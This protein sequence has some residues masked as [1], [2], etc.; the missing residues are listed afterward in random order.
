MVLA[1]STRAITVQGR[2]GVGANTKTRQKYT[3]DII[4]EVGLLEAKPAKIPMEQSHH[5]G[6]AQGRLF[7]DLKQYQ[8]QAALHISRNLVFHEWIKHIEVNCHYIHDELVFGNLDAR[9]VNTKE[10]VADFFTK[11]VGKVY[12]DYLLRKFGVQDL[13]LPTGGDGKEVDT[14]LDGGHDKPLCPPDMLLYSWDGGL[15]ACVD[16]TRSSPL[17]QTEL[18]DFVPRP[19]V[20]DDAQRK[21]ET[22]ARILNMVPTKKV[23]KTPYELWQGKVHNLSYLKVWGCEAHVKRHTADKLEQR[24]VKCIFVGYP[25]ETMGYYFYYP[26]ENKVVVER[27]I[28][29]D[30]EDTIPSENTSKHPIEAENLAP[31]IEEDV[32]PV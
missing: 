22:D 9:H 16:L 13:H 20:I 7:E 24:S 10:Q 21:R 23:D 3:L 1:G 30:D 19:T 8:S 11:A 2:G 6:L 15:D 17:T 32:V 14:E 4:S 25:K 27:T 29:L 12:F 28:E 31:I 26:L 18:V 5:L